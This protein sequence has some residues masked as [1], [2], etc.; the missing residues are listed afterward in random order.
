MDGKFLM[1]KT[2]RRWNFEGVVPTCTSYMYRYVRNS[3]HGGC[4]G[5]CPS[6]RALFL[7]V[8]FSSH[9]PGRSP[10]PHRID[11]DSIDE[12]IILQPTMASNTLRRVGLLAA[13]GT[14]YGGATYLT[15]HYLT[16]AKADRDAANVNAARSQSSYV[17]DPNR[18]ETFQQI[19][20]GYDDQIGKDEFV[21]GIGLMRRA[22]LF[23]HAKGNALEV[24]A[25]TG[26][27]LGKY[28]SSVRKVV[29]TDSSDKMLER[30]K[31][32]I[33]DMSASEQKRYEVVVADSADLSEYKDGSFETVVDT[34]GLCS[35]DDPVQVLKE[36]QRVCRDDGKILL[37]EHGRSKTYEGL[38]KYLDANAERHAKN[39]GCIFN[40]D[41]D[42]LLHAAGLDIE[43]LTTWHFGTTYYVVAKPKSNKSESDA[44][45]VERTNIAAT[46]SR[47]ISPNNSERGQCSCR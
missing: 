3:Y 19:A 29:L 18:T 21:M 39:W 40:R 47:G 37:L 16:S 28:P 1:K 30:A 9:A 38:S 11:A 36:M 41:I 46:S 27:N 43:S 22:L 26:R 15:Y 31:L 6:Q 17:N 13:G 33:K 10:G 35:F 4:H 2:I 25:G 24:G 45:R 44:R 14:A 32:K 8:S 34:F 42:G 20:F 5:R 7:A 12:Q 23:F